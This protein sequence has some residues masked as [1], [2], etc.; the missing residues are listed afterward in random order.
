MNIYW[1]TEYNRII[2]D[3]EIVSKNKW[4]LVPEKVKKAISTKQQTGLSFVVAKDVKWGWCVLDECGLT[5]LGNIEDKFHL[6]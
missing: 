4:K 1:R 2:N 3:G 6:I 5:F